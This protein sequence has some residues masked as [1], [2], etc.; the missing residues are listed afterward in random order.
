MFFA[1]YI[2]E[3]GTTPTFRIPIKHCGKKRVISFY[4]TTH[5]LSTDAMATVLNRLPSSAHSIITGHCIC[6]YN[7]M[8][9]W[10]QNKA[11]IWRQ[12]D[13]N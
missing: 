3:L 12:I 9:E 2:I 13:N 10:K 7:K 5:R 4:L 11:V 6:K 1:V 8:I